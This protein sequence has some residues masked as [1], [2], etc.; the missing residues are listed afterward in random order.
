MTKKTRK[1]ETIAILILFHSF[2]LILSNNLIAQMNEKEKN[3][4]Y[5]GMYHEYN[6]SSS[7]LHLYGNYSYILYYNIR[8][9]SEKAPFEIIKDWDTGF[10]AIDDKILNLYLDDT[11]AYQFNLI[12]TLNIQ[13]LDSKKNNLKLNCPF[14]RDHAFFK[15][16]ALGSK[17]IFMDGCL[18]ERWFIGY[19]HEEKTYKCFYYNSP[20]DRETIK[21]FTLPDT[22]YKRLKE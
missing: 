10:Y 5:I 6:S 18:S 13:L 12:D 7:I 17:G 21:E 1:F 16:Q 3:D 22:I 11:I 20:T 9:L 15:E 4:S 14:H 8:S 19:D 2:C